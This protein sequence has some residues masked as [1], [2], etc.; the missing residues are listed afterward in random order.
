MEVFQKKM[1]KAFWLRTLD[2]V[3][4]SGSKGAPR[5]VPRHSQDKLQEIYDAVF[6]RL[7]EEYEKVD[8]RV[9]WFACRDATKL[10]LPPS[11][12]VPHV[13]L[14]MDIAHFL[15]DQYLEQSEFV[16][17]LRDFGKLLV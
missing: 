15:R 9:F 10:K 7:E 5:N 4:L 14:S 2:H 11:T 13:E 3:V 16:K 17:A 8:T 6:Q 1:E 12:N